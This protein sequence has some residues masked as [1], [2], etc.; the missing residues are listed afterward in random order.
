[1]ESKW[2][3]LI[4]DSCPP[5]CQ[6][7]PVNEEL[8]DTSNGSPESISLVEEVIDQTRLGGSKEIYYIQVR[9]LNSI[10]TEVQVTEDS[11]SSDSSLKVEDERVEKHDLAIMGD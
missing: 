1:M 8:R 7:D 5:S 10:D 3:N 2:A 6:L 11:S 9:D 4:G